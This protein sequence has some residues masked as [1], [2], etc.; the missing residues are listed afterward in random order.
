MRLDHVFSMP[1]PIDEAWGV[2]TDVERIAPC[3]PGAQLQEIEGDE[4]RGLVKV[5]VGPVATQYKGTARFLERDEAERRA[6]IKAEG[7]DARGQGNATAMIS[8]ELTPAVDATDVKISTELSITGRVAQLGRG[9]ISE[10]SDKLLRQFVADLEAMLATNRA[11][12]T[13]DED[14]ASTPADDGIRKIDAPEPPPVDLLDAAGGAIAK[15]LVVVA[16][17]VFVVW[18]LVRRWRRH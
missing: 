10:V 11:E 15:R 16:V 14:V 3:M 17:G 8:M 9:A 5:K 1:L 2:L 12:G 4:Y 7:R 13:A 6:V 18:M